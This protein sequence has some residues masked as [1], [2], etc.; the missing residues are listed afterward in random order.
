MPVTFFE[1]FELTMEANGENRSRWAKLVIPHLS[2][3]A[4]QVF[5]T[6]VPP[7]H[8]DCYREI[9]E[10]ILSGL[11]D[12]PQAA[13]NKWWTIQRKQ[14]ESYDSFVTTLLNLNDRRWHPYSTRGVT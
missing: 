10:R 14:Q 9:K 3:K 12:T 4:K 1:N 2:E 6:D 7:E 8:R 13:A 11:G 5:Q